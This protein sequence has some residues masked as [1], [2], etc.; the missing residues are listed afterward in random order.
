ME[1]EGKSPTKQHTS[2]R[3]LVVLGDAVN[4][5][6]AASM[7]DMR[8]ES[9]PLDRPAAAIA[10]SSTSNVWSS[11]D[12]LAP[13]ATA[14]VMVYFC[15]NRQTRFRTSGKLAQHE[16]V[17]ITSDAAFRCSFCPKRFA[18]KS[19]ASRH[20][21]THTGEKPYACSMCPGRFD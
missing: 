10:S 14:G 15:G 21:R 4:T 5:S 3:S 12:A 16:Q 9:E 18:Q 2:K 17:H 7:R 1:T 13:H 11:T 6:G 8:L 19:A 20:E